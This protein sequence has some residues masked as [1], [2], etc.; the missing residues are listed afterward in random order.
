MDVTLQ[1]LHQAFSTHF[2]CA[3]TDLSALCGS[4]P[5]ILT[6]TSEEVTIIMATLEVKKPRHREV[7]QLA[8][9]HTALKW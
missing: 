9:G 3:R 6:V 7:Q 4:I 2:L 1:N 8:Q 5:A